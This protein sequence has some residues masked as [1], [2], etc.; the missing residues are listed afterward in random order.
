M[1]TGKNFIELK[2]SIATEAMKDKKL[3]E[4]LKDPKELEKKLGSPQQWGAKQYKIV[5]NTQNKIYLVILNDTVVKN[6]LPPKELKTP[7]DYY[8]DAI[9]KISKD[10]E[11]RKRYIANPKEVLQKEFSHLGI[12]LT[13]NVAIEILEDNDQVIHFVLPCAATL[14]DELLMSVAGGGEILPSNDWR[15]GMKDTVNQFRK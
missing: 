14:S 2:N 6:L 7:N 8:I 15:D 3:W 11:L 4:K 1:P 5:A 12:V 10:K 13:S 9:I